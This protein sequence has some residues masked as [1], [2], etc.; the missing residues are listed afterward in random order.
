MPL[1][2]GVLQSLQD[3]LANARKDVPRD[4]L[5]PL[6]APKPIAE[7]AKSEIAP[8]GKRAASEKKIAALTAAVTAMAA[9][10]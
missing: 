3:P 10:A 2:P 7:L 8:G 1:L 5:A 6:I 4:S 9:R